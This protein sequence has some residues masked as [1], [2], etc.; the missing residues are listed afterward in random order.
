MI[1]SK[2]AEKSRQTFSKPS[3]TSKMDLFAK[4]LT[5][6]TVKYFRKKPNPKF[7]TGF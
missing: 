5:D 6:E 4:K 7:Q 3:Q 1:F 2:T